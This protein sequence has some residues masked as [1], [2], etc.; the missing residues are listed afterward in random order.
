MQLSERPDVAAFCG[1]AQRHSSGCAVG[2]CNSRMTTPG[3]PLTVVVIFISIRANEKE[4]PLRD[5]EFGLGF[6]DLKVVP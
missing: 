6:H 2:D 3:P 1:N 4:T 5:T